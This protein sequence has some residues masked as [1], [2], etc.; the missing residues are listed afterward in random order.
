MLAIGIAVSIIGYF[1]KDLITEHKET[2]KMSIENKSKLEL[3]ANDHQH[4]NEKFDNLLA[5]LKELTQEVKN[6]SITMA[7][8]KNNL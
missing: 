4:L 2:Q 6:L 5:S 1:L 7:T 8:L 3:I